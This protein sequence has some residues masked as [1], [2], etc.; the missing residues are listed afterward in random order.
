MHILEYYMP[1][2]EDN[3]LFPDTVLKNHDLLNS[4]LKEAV[5]KKYIL[6]NPIGGVDHPKRM[7]HEATVTCLNSL[8]PFFGWLKVTG[9]EQQCS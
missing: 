3:N 9:W 7:Q 2:M 8:N 1:L 5:R 4:M 6:K